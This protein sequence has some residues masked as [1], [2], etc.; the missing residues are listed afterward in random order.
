MQR[1]RHWVL[2]VAAV[3]WVAAPASASTIGLADIQACGAVSTCSAGGATATAIGGDFSWQSLNGWDGYGVSG[4]SVEGEIDGGEAIEIAFDAPSLVQ[5]MQLIFLYEPPTYNDVEHGPTDDEAASIEAFAGGIS[6]GVVT[7][8]VT[9][10][11]TAT[12]GA[13]T[14]LSIADETGGGAW[15]LTS[16]F[17]SQPIDLLRITP[18]NPGPDASYSDLSLGTTTFEAVPVPEPV[19]VLLVGAGLV[20]LGRRRRAWIA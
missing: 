15:L 14:N 4:G 19:S 3:L 20:G 6:L 9:G 13:L 2:A 8:Q 18:A 16:P 1:I 10:F 5:S 17:G 11:T 12:G 7:V